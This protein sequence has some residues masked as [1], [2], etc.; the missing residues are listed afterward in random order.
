[1]YINCTATSLQH[2]L[3]C[4]LWFLSSKE[5]ESGKYFIYFQHTYKITFYMRIENIH[6]IALY[7]DF[8]LVEKIN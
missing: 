6:L 5:A 3:F 8:L 4:T 1:M 2:N 7:F